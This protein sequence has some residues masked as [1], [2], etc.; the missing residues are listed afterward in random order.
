MLTCLSALLV[1]LPTA[2]CGLLNG[3][4]NEGGGNANTHQLEKPTIT[5]G[6]MQ[7][8]DTAPFFLALKRGYFRDEGLTVQVK[9]V[10]GGAESVPLLTGEH[11]DVGFGNWATLLQAQAH[12][13]AE[14]RIVADGDQGRSHVMIVAVRPDSSIKTPADLVDKT[15][16]TNTPDDV[17]LLAL[18][19]ILRA[20]NLDFNRVHTTTVHHADTPTALANKAVDAAIQLEPFITK[21]R[22][23]T[24]TEAVVD[25]FGPGPTQDLPL[26]GYFSLASFV[27]KSPKSAAAFQRALQRGAAD[28]ADE[29]AVRQ[30]LPDYTGID[31]DTAMLV[32]IPTFPTSLSATRLQRV[33]D[34]MTTY[35]QLTDKIDVGPLVFTPAS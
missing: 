2:S 6:V 21:A 35:G 27:Q 28:A 16:S 15:V 1:G 32:T 34:L 13:S 4:S 26:A 10:Q 33:A 8:I 30:I 23:Q 22:E 12:H 9:P 25:L 5:V 19:A 11:I 17:P 3:P 18:R 29:Q 20:D 14:Y 7:T 31:R 24:G